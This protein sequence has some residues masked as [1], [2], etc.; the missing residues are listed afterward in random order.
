MNVVM[1][2]AC[3]TLGCHLGIHIQQGHSIVLGCLPFPLSVLV[4]SLLTK[5]TSTGDMHTLSDLGGDH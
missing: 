2:H 1:H 5:V 3:S 4:P